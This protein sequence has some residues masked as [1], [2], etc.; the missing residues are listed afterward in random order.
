MKVPRANKKKNNNNNNNNN[1]NTELCSASG[2]GPIGHVLFLIFKSD[3]SSA[4]IGQ[5]KLELFADDVMS[6][7]IH[8]PKQEM[9][10]SAENIP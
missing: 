3:I 2:L 1:N 5:A 8:P 9:M 10:G 4:C 7:Y 6:C